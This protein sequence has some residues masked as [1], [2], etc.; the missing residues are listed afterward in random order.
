MALARGVSPASHRAH[1][2]AVLRHATDLRSACVHAVRVADVAVCDPFDCSAPATVGNGR[3]VSYQRVPASQRGLLDARHRNAL[4]PVISARVRALRSLSRGFRYRDDRERS[5]LPVAGE[6]HGFR[7][8]AVL[9]ARNRRGRYRRS[10]SALAF[11]GL[12]DEHRYFWG[13]ELAR[14]TNAGRRG[15][16]GVDL[17][18]RRFSNRRRRNGKP[19]SRVDLFVSRFHGH[20]DCFI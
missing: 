4:V 20:R 14:F 10:R 6:Y 17:A 7:H 12:A 18:T 15:S 16:H 2:S 11:G 8:A 9:H 1:R 3:R 13:R 19:A 5:A